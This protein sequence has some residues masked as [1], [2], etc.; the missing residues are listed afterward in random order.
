MLLCR[1][2]Q[3]CSYVLDRT[4]ILLMSNWI[5]AIYTVGDAFG[6]MILQW[7][8][9]RVM[10]F[11]L[12]RGRST[13]SCGDARLILLCTLF[14]FFRSCFQIKHARWTWIPAV[15]MITWFV[16]SFLS[17]LNFFGNGAFDS[18]SLACSTQLGFDVT[19]THPIRL[20]ADMVTYTISFL[21]ATSNGFSSTNCMMLGTVDNDQ[22]C[23]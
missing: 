2:A 18:S 13:D 11:R 7:C 12:V 21:F 20:L 14:A 5:V 1:G 3:A 9:F 22:P 6:R 17:G 10:S 23:R 16:L 15:F 19:R 4:G 8:A